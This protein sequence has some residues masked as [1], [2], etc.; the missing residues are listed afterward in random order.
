MAHSCHAESLS[1]HA[2]PKSRFQVL[3]GNAVGAALPQVRQAEPANGV[4]S[5]SLG[6]RQGLKPLLQNYAYLL[7]CSR[8]FNTHR[9]GSNTR[10]RVFYTRC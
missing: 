4:P 6:T 1:P 9:R 7:T 5:Q 8:V 2:A 3:P 10:W